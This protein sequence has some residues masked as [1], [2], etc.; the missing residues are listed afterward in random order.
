M[1]TRPFPDPSTQPD[2]AQLATCMGTAFHAVSAAVEVVRKDHRT[3]THTL[4]FSK[5][6]GWHL[7]YDKGRQ[8]LFYL[9]PKTGGYLLKMVFNE[10]GVAAL[11]H[12]APSAAVLEKLRTARTYAEGTLLEFT[13]VEVDAPV[14]AGLLRIKI[15]SVG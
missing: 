15:A 10:R 14:L 7:T 12:D 8:R 4:K 6:S 5:T 2:L 11:E 9:F 3:I 13:A 1:E